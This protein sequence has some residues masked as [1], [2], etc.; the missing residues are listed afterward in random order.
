[1]V[2]IKEDSSDKGPRE[3][4]EDISRQVGGILGATAPGQL[5]RDEKQVSNMK[6]RSQQ[7]TLDSVADELFVVMQRAYAQDTMNKFI[8]DIKTAPEPAIVLADDQQLADL[9][10]FCTSSL[11]F[12]VLTV[13]PT[14][15]LGDF[16]VT[17]ITYRHLLLETRRSGQTP[18]FLGPI[19]VHYKKTFASYLFFA[20]SLIGQNKQLEG[21][22]AIGTDGEQAL[23]DAFMHE[24]GFA[25]HL[26]CFIH[27]RRNI[28]DKLN[29][30]AIPPELTA[31]ILREIFGQRLG[32]VFQEGL[33]DSS[34]TED[35][36]NKL[37]HL[38]ESWRNSEMPSTS[39][40]DKFV[41]WFM[42]HKAGVI[43]NT[44]LRPVREECGLG[45]P[46]SIS[47]QMPVKVLMLS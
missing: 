34:D 42:T 9:Q 17:P 45:N 6:R 24:F 21:V 40:I 1:M 3:I 11:D 28:K 20:S 19:L 41:N 26:T 35:Y 22:R 47:Q 30:C 8:R 43:Q 18:V 15:S 25:Q 12:G 5:P 31:T 16:D 14:F 23:I 39:D 27:V 33:V 29:E 38:V 10:R 46:P 44:M 32:P 37:N 36:D 4:V 7:G 2:K 13:D